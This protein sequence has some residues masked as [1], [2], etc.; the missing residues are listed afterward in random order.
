MTEVFS[1]LFEGTIWKMDVYEPTGLLAIEWRDNEGVPKFSVIHF[2]SGELAIDAISYGDRWWTL[3]AITSK[4]LLLH[5]Y[6]QANQAQTSGLVAID[7][8]TGLVAWERFNLQF[9]EATKEGIAVK[10]GFS[11]N[12]KVA[13]LDEH[14]GTTSIAAVDLKNLGAYDRN[15]RPALPTNAMPPITLTKQAIIGPYFFLEHGIRQLWAYHVEKEN[16]FRLNLAI[17]EGEEVIFNAGIIDHL[18]HLLPETFFIIDQQ[19]FFIR[20]NKR[21]IVS[22]FV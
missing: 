11:S 7:I 3:A 21:E 20:N 12:N 8:A 15:I 1:H 17:I 19:L 5:H 2:S 13:V 10:Q 18:N 9:Q 22:Y 6:P 14:T 16:G 4:H